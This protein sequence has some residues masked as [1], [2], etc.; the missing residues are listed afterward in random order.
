MIP[1][2][3]NIAKSFLLSHLVVKFEPFN[4]ILDS[5]HPKFVK[6]N[7]FLQ[8]LWNL[9]VLAVTC[10]KCS[11]LYIGWYLGGFWCGVATSFLS[12]LYSQVILPY[13]D[14]IRLQ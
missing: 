1:F 12:Y 14:K 6:S 13:V 10:L 3:I 2:L 8:L 4:W 11:S 7:K 5:L 9:F